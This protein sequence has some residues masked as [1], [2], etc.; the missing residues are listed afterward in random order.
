MSEQ[1]FGTPAVIDI[2]L[3]VGLCGRD[4][5]IVVRITV[6]THCFTSNF[7]VQY[8]MTSAAT[9]TKVAKISV[10]PGSVHTA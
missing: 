3:V 5:V 9:I 7:Q 4:I 6:Q 10:G 8:D 2:R 1:F